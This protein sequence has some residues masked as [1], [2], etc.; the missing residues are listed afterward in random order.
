MSQSQESDDAA[1]SGL[2]AAQRIALH[3][4][5]LL[6]ARFHDREPDA[7]ML[8]ALRAQPA[9]GWLS[10]R[11]EGGEFAVARTLLNDAFAG[12]PDPVDAAALD[13][14]A[15]EFAALH[16]NFTYRAAPAESPWR[17]DEGLERQ[18]AM[19][20]VRRWYRRLGLAAAD[21]RKRSDDHI[22]TELTFLARA[23]RDADSAAAILLAAR[24]LRE[25]PLAWVPHFAARARKCCR[26]PLFAGFAVLTSA[27]L[28]ELA[29]LLASLT[30]LDMLAPPLQTSS[31]PDAGAGPT[32][33]EPQPNRIV[34]A[35]TSAPRTGIHTNAAS[36]I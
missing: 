16:L 19:F 1:P 6:L 17:D 20:A 3:D 4:D 29:E 22:V 15:A 8:S 35:A 5:L 21:W 26:L 28:R 7:E 27:Y 23:L 2:T 36:A 14:L 13:E 30:K 32:C 24:F 34:N 11:L 12:L 9:D 31:G 18:H 10:L 33:G 25:H